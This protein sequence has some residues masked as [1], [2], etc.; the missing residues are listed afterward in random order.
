MT[1]A[2]STE[3]KGQATHFVDKIWQSLLRDDIHINFVEFNTKFKEVLPLIGNT[4]IGD[5]PQKKH[6]IRADKEDRW[7]PGNNIHFV[8]NNR[9][10]ERFQFAPVVKCEAVQKITIKHSVEKWRQPWVSVDNKLLTGPEIETLAINDGF[11]SSKE[12]FQYF[13]KDFKGKIIHWTKL[14]Y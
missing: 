5:Y 13:N 12:F 10:P 4:K 1:L 9:T 14:K 3:L 8:I 7:K 11:E 2:F 6:T